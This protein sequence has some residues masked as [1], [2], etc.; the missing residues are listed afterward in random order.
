M[1]F[2]KS[3]V[4]CGCGACAAICPAD[5][6]SMSSDEGG[7]PLPTV[8]E[9]ACKN[10]GLCESVCPGLTQAPSETQSVFEPQYYAAIHNDANVVQ[11]SSSGGIFTAITDVILAD[12]GVVYGCVSECVT[13]AVH[14]RAET[15]LERDA[16]RGSKYI[17]SSSFGFYG[18]VAADLKN[19]R[20]VYFSG[21]PC[22]AAALKLYLKAKNIPTDRFVVQEVLCHGVGSPRFFNSYIQYMEDKYG[23]K[24]VRCSFRAKAAK[25]KNQDME[26]IFDNGKRYNA[27][28][29]SE[30]MFY[31]FYHRNLILRESCYSCRFA[32]PKRQSDISL[33]DFWGYTGENIGEQVS[34]CV[35]SSLAGEKLL[36]EAKK[37]LTLRVSTLEEANSNAMLRAAPRPERHGA[38]WND[39]LRQGFTYISK[40]YG[41]NNFKGKLKLS[42]L[43]IINKSGLLP[44]VKKILKK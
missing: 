28:S 37:A 32:V 3:E 42:A 6:I 14:T 11:K 2:C 18:E 43:L 22:Q 44:L 7:F 38:F 17:Q 20:R 31:K 9:S 19:E 16:M 27:I 26:I 36:S 29:T 4:C 5:C 40:K 1:T 12:G 35:V 33:G 41:S 34:L 21:T 13:R 39:F 8:N 24:A 15:A 30:D 23:G 25:G 10:C